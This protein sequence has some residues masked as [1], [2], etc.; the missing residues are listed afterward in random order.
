MRV[1]TV[2][3]ADKAQKEISDG[4]ASAAQALGDKNAVAPFFRFPYLD[5]TGAAEERPMQL[6]LSIWSADFHGSDWTF[7]NA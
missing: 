6:G 4:L 5:H 3:S 1:S 7:I 2:M